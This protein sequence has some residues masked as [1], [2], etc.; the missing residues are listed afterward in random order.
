[1]RLFLLIGLYFVL[2][3]KGVLA[4]SENEIRRGVYPY[5]AIIYYADESVVVSSGSRFVRSAVLIRPEWLISSSL[6]TNDTQLA[7]PRKT[8]LARVGAI[9]LDVNFTF[10]EDEDEQEREIIQIVRPTNFSASS[11]WYNDITLLKT[12]LPFNMTTAVG[13]T[14]LSPKRDSVD[15]TCYILVFAK[16]YANSSDE[17]VLMQLAV[18]L[19]PPSSAN[20]G[21]YYRKDTTIC[22]SD[23]DENKHVAYDTDFCYGNSGGPLICEGDVIGLQTYVNTCK[24]P[25]LYQLMSAWDDFISCG[26]DDKCL[27]SQ[28]ANICEDID[29]DTVMTV[30][31][32]KVMPIST[33]EAPK[34]LVMDMPSED[35]SEEE[36]ISLPET[37]KAK[38]TAGNESEKPT[39]TASSTA[40]VTTGTETTPV[41]IT[42]NE[43]K[44]T[45]IIDSAT[46]WP[47]EKFE[48]HRKKLDEADDSDKMER[49]TNVEAQRHEVKKKARNAAA[50]HV[51]GVAGL[52]RSLSFG[53]LFLTCII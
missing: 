16:K 19:L 47:K 31:T 24:P 18:E 37:T 30:E 34:M 4:D 13:S 8:L 38:M 48:E 46:S 1:M 3:L 9:S 40:E 51:T 27:L 50:S 5:M 7:F 39:P 2:S 20:C 11:W 49:K 22:A 23:S 6:E 43:D 32:N 21:A 10:N 29:K 14:A 42:E 28:C 45:R 41:A 44:S 35:T 33:T 53:V 26:V 12:L 52:F 15:K 36:R 25:Y 17:K